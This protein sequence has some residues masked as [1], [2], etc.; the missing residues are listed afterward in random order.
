MV[1][2]SSDYRKHLAAVVED[3]FDNRSRVWVSARD[4]VLGRSPQVWRGHG[5]RGRPATH[6]TQVRRPNNVPPDR[7]AWS[8]QLSPGGVAGV[9]QV[10]G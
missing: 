4:S 3:L 8:P 2:I 10:L 6:V 5:V 9:E 1:G 7:P